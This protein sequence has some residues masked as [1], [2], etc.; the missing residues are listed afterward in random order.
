MVEELAAAA[1]SLTGQVLSVTEALRL[2]R[3]R[4]DQPSIAEADA[5]ALRRSNQEAARSADSPDG[6]DFNAA[7]EKH[8]Q[9]KT[10]LRNAALHGEQLDA[11]RIGRDD[12]CP[13]GQWLH[14]E[15]GR[16]WGRL[17]RFTE[18]L[19]DHAQFHQAAGKV[20]E[21]VNRGDREVAQ[22]LMEGGSVFVDATQSVVMSIKALQA[23]MRH[24]HQQ[25]A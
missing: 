21:A 2:F 23:E 15:G 22:R 25:H 7:I 24:T 9:W 18:L 6:F 3:L 17:P 14:G 4:A 13:L 1:Q 16:A 12:C 20:A 19:T 5:V 10:T 8:M 11:A